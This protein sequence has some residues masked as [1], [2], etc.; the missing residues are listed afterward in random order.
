MSLVAPGSEPE[1]LW[2]GAEWAEGPAWLAD[3][4]VLLFS[5]IPNDRIMAF[6]SATGETTVHREHVEFANGRTIDLDGA[7]VQC[8]HGRRAIEREVNGEVVT[9]ADR[10]TGGR[11][12]SPN[13]V[14]VASDGAIWFTDPPYGL[15][16]SGR[17]GHPGK[18]DYAGCFVFRFDGS[19]ATPVITDMVHPNGLAFS[20]DESLLYVADTG[21]FWDDTVALQIRVYDVATG[22]GRVFVTPTGVADGFRVDASGRL[23]TSSGASIEVYSPEAELLLTIPFPERVSNLCFGGPDGTDLYVTAS[24]SLYRLPTLT[25]GAARP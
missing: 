8:S 5:D 22:D 4:G 11:F 14:V 13:D 16:E 25:T 10:W 3:R 6:D 19:V 9:I 12:N 15:H 7:V 1:L 2:T 17:E 18:Q 24:T 21:W 23:W 20:P